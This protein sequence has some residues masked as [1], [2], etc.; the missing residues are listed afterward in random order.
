VVLGNALYFNGTW[1]EKFNPLFT[2]TNTFHLIDG[3]TI[4]T[5]F[6][7][8]SG[9]QFISVHE[10]FKVLKLP[11]K[12][13]RDWR[14]FSFYIFLPD[15]SNDGLLNLSTKLSSEPDFLN[16]HIPMEKV[17]VDDFRIP[18]FNISMEFQFS[19]IFQNLGLV[20][21]FKMTGDFSEMVDSPQGEKYY[22]S[23]IVHKCFVEVNEE[24]TEAAA[25]SAAILVGCGS[26]MGKPIDFVADHPFLFLIREDTSGVVLFMGLLLNP[27]STA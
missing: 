27:L 1:K 21:P 3:G 24:G 20:L 23:E 15:N 19:D 25:A 4:K 8:S 10:G 7:S 26:W 17:Q 11:Y 16:Q 13:G 9:R 12:Q 6:M 18:K 14:Q 2:K 5:P 22:V